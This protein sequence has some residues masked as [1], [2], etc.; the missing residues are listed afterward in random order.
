M[1]SVLGIFAAE[2]ATGKD[3]LEQFS[4][5]A[6]ALSAAAKHQ[7]PACLAGKS[8][9]VALRSQQ[10]ITE[11][12]FFNFTQE[13]APPPPKPVFSPAGQVGAIAPLGYFDPLGFCQ[14]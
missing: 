5:R 1:L 9:S 8:S 3:A 10:I 12:R 7:K 2:F 6:T 4:L 13:P 11:R 14:E